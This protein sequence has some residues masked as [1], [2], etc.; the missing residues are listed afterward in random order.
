MSCRVKLE[1]LAVE[2]GSKHWAKDEDLQ[3]NND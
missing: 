2:E 3:V 1:D